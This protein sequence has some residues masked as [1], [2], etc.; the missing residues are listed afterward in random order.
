MLLLLLLCP[1]T[2]LSTFLSTLF[3]YIG[4]LE[5]SRTLHKTLLRR[6]LHAPLT[7]FFDITPVGRVLNRFSKDIDT[8]DSDLPATLRA[9]IT[10]RY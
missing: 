10:L 6:V 8:T 7:S 3:L 4:A 2:V 9:W 1:T 5:A